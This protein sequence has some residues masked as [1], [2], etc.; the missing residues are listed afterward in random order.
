[1]DIGKSITYIFE[2]PR[3]LTKVLVGTV[4]LLVSIPLTVLLIGF[5]GIAIVSGYGLE[6][7][8]NV[9]QRQPY[10]MPEWR[11]RW[12]EWLILGLKLLIAQL[13]WSLPGILLSIPM[14]LG[15]ALTD[16]QNSEFI[17]FVLLTCFGCLTLLWSVVVLVAT[18]AIYIRLAEQETLSSTLQF[19]EIIQ[20]TRDHVGDVLVAIIVYV[21]LSFL[22]MAAASLLGLVLCLVG[23]VITIPAGSFIVTLIQSHLY[24]QVGLGTPDRREI[25]PV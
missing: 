4:I 8:R 5:L 18:P 3:W 9:R 2:D 1:M 21:L 20:F 24:G 22:V 11:D 19:G 25:Q 13:V 23:L 6:V 16:N 10:P 12:G 17:G 15:S 14:S 7:I